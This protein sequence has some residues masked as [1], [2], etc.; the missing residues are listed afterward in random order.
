MKRNGFTLIELLVVIAI[1]AVLAAVLFP[2]FASV[3]EKARQATCANNLRQIGSAI[4]LYTEDWDGR[5]FYD[6]IILPITLRQYLGQVNQGVWLC[7]NDP[8]LDVTFQ[9]RMNGHAYSSYRGDIKF[10]NSKLRYYEAC[11]DDARLVEA[12]KRPSS[13]IM[14]ID[15]LMISDFLKTSDP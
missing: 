15:G 4:T 3:Q 10:F 1:I 13:T 12:V 9:S 2:V 8:S 7:P 6:L 11:L 5:Y 14:V